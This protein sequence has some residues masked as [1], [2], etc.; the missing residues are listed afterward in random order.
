MGSPSTATHVDRSSPAPA[1]VA[2]DA[3][4]L[5]A[6][7]DRLERQFLYIRDQLRHTQRLASLGT[8]SA[9]LA[10]EFNNLFT[11]IVAY[12]QQ[13]LETNDVDL[14]RKAI[15]K[16][17]ANTEIM[18]Q[19]AD[20][21]VGM[22]K[23]GESGSSRYPVLRL[24]EDALGCLCRD[25]AKDNIAVTINIDPSLAVRVNGHQIQQVL[26]N[27]I[28][29]ARQAMLG[30]RGRLTIDAEPAG[31]GR[32]ALHVRDTG[33]GIPPENLERI[34][35]PFFSTKQNEQKPDRR[36]LGLGLAICRDLVDEN[37]GTIDVE[38]RVGAGTTFRLILPAAE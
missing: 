28:L 17:L 20:R 18:R 2:A 3:Q 4:A 15:Q 12:G 29:N 5:Q 19:M 31:D 38:S 37:R 34:F 33:C 11:P 14:M 9:M 26:F 30:R 8:L 1:S 25:L 23:N 7:F 35:E 32:V 21:L 16:T 22:V 27:L 10:H 6:Q 36:G 13:A 24:V